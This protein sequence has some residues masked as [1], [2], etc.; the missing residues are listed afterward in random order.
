MAKKA[1]APRKTAAKPA[2]SAKARPASRTSAPKRAKAKPR[3]RS[4]KSRAGAKKSSKPSASKRRKKAAHDCVANLTAGVRQ[5]G[6]GLRQGAVAADPRKL[7][8]DTGE[9][10]RQIKFDR[11]S[12]FCKKEW[13]ELAAL[14]GKLQ[15]LA[16]HPEHPPRRRAKQ[17]HR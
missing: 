14:A 12:D 15:E 16:S 7:I 10:I 4:A 5:I 2:K 6:L 9:K 8:H 1:R 3:A 11:V 17:T 13:H